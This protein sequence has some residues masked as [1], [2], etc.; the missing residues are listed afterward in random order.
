MFVKLKKLFHI[1]TYR[2]RVTFHMKSGRSI[3]VLCDD[4]TYKSDRVTGSL[5]EYSI[6]GARAGDMNFISMNDV[7]AISYKKA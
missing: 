2:I 1:A 4:M 6:T 3:V 5:T 7:E